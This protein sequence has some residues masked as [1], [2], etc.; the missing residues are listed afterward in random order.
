MNV[1]S[2]LLYTQTHVW[3]KLEEDNLVRVG[4][5]DYAQQE[6][7]D[8]VYLDLPRVGKYFQVGDDCATVESVKAASE[9]TAPVSGEIKSVNDELVDE[10]ELVNDDPYGSWLFCIEAEDLD[11]L[12]D[13]MDSDAYQDFID[14]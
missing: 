11:E 9:L 7:G 6:L 4:I 3:V 12:D 1:P 10:P 5:T 13:L 8:L 14:E 2:D